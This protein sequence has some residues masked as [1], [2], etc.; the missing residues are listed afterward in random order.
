MRADHAEKND[1]KPWLEKQ[2]VIPPKANAEFVCAME[3][4]L[5]VYKRPYDPRFPV[6]CLDEVSK[7][8]VGETRTPIAASAGH[9]RRVD[10]EYERKGTANL[11]MTFE[12]LVGK[13]WVKVTERR[14]AIDFAEV[15][16][17]LVDARYAQ[18]AKIVLVMDNLNTHK[19][20][21][22]YEA[23]PPAEARRLLERLEI[24]HTPKHGSW[25]NMAETELS[26]LSGQCLK[27]RIAD[28]K[29]LTR[30]AAAWEK[31]RNN[32]KCRVDW[33]FTTSKARIK[34][35]RLYPSLQLC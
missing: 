30:E 29:T 24:H 13:R 17:E 32:A 31:S 33:Q 20:A 11:F 3:D 10:Y 28:I 6:V 35:K 25:L 18:A 15:V 4:V 19:L 2:W 8:L 7:Q 22:L 14:T 23:F 26:V 16:R 5:E 9:P 21:S 27:R 34:L 1:L 12:P